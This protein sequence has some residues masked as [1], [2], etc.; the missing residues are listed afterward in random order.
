MNTSK[1]S[2]NNMNSLPVIHTS[3]SHTTFHDAT[4][5]DPRLSYAAIGLLAYLLSRPPGWKLKVR[6]LIRPGLAGRDQINSLLR[7]LIAT[8]Y[9]TKEKRRNPKPNGI[10]WEYTVREQA[11][12]TSPSSQG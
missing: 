12:E 11:E 3:D 5:Q 6:E 8:G 9:V 10:N 1:T 4:I 2:H 7:E